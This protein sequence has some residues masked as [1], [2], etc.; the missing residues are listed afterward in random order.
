M[1]MTLEQVRAA[2]EAI[3]PDY[4]A[5]ARLG[6]DAFP[7][8][9]TLARDPDPLLASKAVYLAGMIRD[10]RSAE[11]VRTGAQSPD[12]RVRIAAASAARNLPA[13]EASAVL[14]TLVG[15]ADLGVRKTVLKSVPADASADL[16][17]RVQAA[18]R[19]EPEAALR[20]LG[21]EALRRM[22]PQE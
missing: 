20:Q 14:T 9:Q 12:P 22:R 15:D 11:V 7:H 19:R 5:L 2:L 4:P 17:A 10:A 16:R 8:L 18:A 3:E 1:A 6:A 21:D 13:A